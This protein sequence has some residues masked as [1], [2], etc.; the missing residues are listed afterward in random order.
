MSESIMTILKY[1]TAAR[2]TQPFYIP[3]LHQRKEYRNENID[4]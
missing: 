3:T 4:Y 2:K 1:K